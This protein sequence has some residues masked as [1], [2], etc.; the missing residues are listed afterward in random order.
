MEEKRFIAVRLRQTFTETDTYG[1]TVEE[2]SFHGPSLKEAL[3]GVDHMAAR[4]H[5]LKGRHS[6]WEIVNHCRFWMEAATCAVHGEAL[7][8]VDGIEDWPRAGQSA[9]EWETDLGRLD[10]SLEKLC[11]AVQSMNPGS[12]TSRRGASSM[13]ASSSSPSGRCFTEFMTTTCTTRARYPS[14]SLG[15][16]KPRNMCVVHTCLRSQ[17]LH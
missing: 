3:R 1:P 15:E 17:A 7:P 9:S 4:L 10:E 12:W 8:G 16:Y 6:I 5:T 14:S 2:G 11:E 13:D